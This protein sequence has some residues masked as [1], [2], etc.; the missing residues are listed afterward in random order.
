M[1]VDELRKNVSEAPY[2]NSH[3]YFMFKEKCID[4]SR[5][6]HTKLYEKIPTKHSLSHMSNLELMRDLFTTQDIF[7]SQGVYVHIDINDDDDFCTFE[8][9]IS[10]ENPTPSSAFRGFRREL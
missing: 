9:F 10:W 1:L 7:R 5:K 2:D 8:V 3:I 4:A 6:G